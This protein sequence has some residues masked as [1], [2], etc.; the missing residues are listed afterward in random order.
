LL[1]KYRLPTEAEWEY[2]ALALVGNSLG[3]RVLE[4]NVY[5]WHGKS[6]R[7]ED[8]NSIGQFQMNFKRGKGDYMGVATMPNPGY[9]FPS[10]VKSFWP[11]DFGLYNMAGNVSEW[12]LDVYRP[13]T[14]E[15]AYG[16]NPFRGNVYMTKVL[17]EDGLVAEKDSLGR[18]RFQEMT[19]EQIANRRNFQR[20]DNRNFRDGDFS[21]AIA[22]DWLALAEEGGQTTDLVYDAKSSAITDYSRV[23]KGGN[24]QDRAY[25]L[26]PAGRR[27]LDQDRSESWI[28]FRCAMPRIGTPTQGGSARARR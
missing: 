25:W 9:L 3:E 19:P 14:F 18:I 26:A 24:F 7:S 1:P 12:V 23:V 4:R 16:M 15:E 21:S 27:F 2:A 28:G 8:K 22:S 17:D 20:A 10:E 11:N 13:L 5:P 6:L